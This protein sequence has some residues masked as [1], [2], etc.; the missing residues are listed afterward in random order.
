MKTI[1]IWILRVQQ[2]KKVKKTNLQEY[3][4]II[5]LIPY[6]LKKTYP[7]CFILSYPTTN[8]VNL[9]WTLGIKLVLCEDLGSI[10]PTFYTKL[11]CVQIPKPWKNT[12][13]LTELLHFWD[14]RI[15]CWWNGEPSILLLQNFLLH[16]I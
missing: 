6:F 9:I 11:L 16:K 2:A 5:L 13:N 1:H 15:K 4:N 3:I 14:L 8:E 12:D 7:F 10:S